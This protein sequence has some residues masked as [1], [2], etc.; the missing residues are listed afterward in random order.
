MKNEILLWKTRIK[1]NSNLLL[2]IFL[3]LLSL[4]IYIIT[5]CPSLA[6]RD[7]AELTTGAYSL[8]ITHPPGYPLFTLLG[9]LFTFIPLGNILFLWKEYYFRG[10]YNPE[11][12]DAFNFN[13]EIIGYYIT[14]QYEMIKLIKPC[15]SEEELKDIIK[16]ID[17]LPK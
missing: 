12:Q 3:F 4:F 6:S 17:V 7:S 14:A 13:R 16:Q 1:E 9:K 15:V 8:N 10:S 2:P 5:L 11:Y